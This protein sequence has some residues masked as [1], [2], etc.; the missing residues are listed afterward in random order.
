MKSIIDSW[1]I[2]NSRIDQTETNRN[3][4]RAEVA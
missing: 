1:N 4:F 3:D 2:H